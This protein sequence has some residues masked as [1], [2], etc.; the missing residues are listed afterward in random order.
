MVFESQMVKDEFCMN[1]S[2]G[3]RTIASLRKNRPIDFILED[4][5]NTTR[6]KVIL[7]FIK[8]PVKNF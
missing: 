7:L 8:I 5:N 1:F 4:Y 2:Y 3:P 6:Y